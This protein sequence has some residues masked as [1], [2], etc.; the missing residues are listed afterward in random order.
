VFWQYIHQK[1]DVIN[2]KLNSNK[3]R[4]TKKTT[5]EKQPNFMAIAT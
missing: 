2:Q 1:N 3:K 4:A 5:E